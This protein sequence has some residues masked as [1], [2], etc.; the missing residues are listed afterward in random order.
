MYDV[1]LFLL[2]LATFVC[3]AL[4]AVT[5]L[6]LPVNNN[7]TNAL[8]GSVQI[9]LCSAVYFVYRLCAELLAAVRE[10]RSYDAVFTVEAEDAEDAEDAEE[11]R[12]VEPVDVEPVN[13]EPAHVKDPDTA[14]VERQRERDRKRERERDAAA[15][16]ALDALG[17]GADTDDAERP[18][19]FESVGMLREHIMLVHMTG[20]LVWH[21]VLALDYTQP[22]LAYSFTCGIVGAWLAQVYCYCVLRLRAARDYS[23]RGTAA[24][25]SAR[26]PPPPSYPGA[27]WRGDCHAACRCTP[28]SVCS[29]PRC[30]RR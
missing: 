8:I 25:H 6:A 7:T 10:R 30:S 19:V 4:S 18:V 12:D 20:F 24:N 5:T 13:V 26:R 21:S 3:A 2:K 9:L 11:L 17:V 14:L 16:A 29:V 1:V 28:C 15:R 27:V 23:C 22:A